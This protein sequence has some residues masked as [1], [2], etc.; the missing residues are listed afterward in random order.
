MAG[1]TKARFMVF[2]EG[3]TS[4]SDYLL[5]FKKGV[6]ISLLPIQPV[7]AKCQSHILSVLPNTAVFLSNCSHPFKTLKVKVYPVFTPN[8]YFWKNH[9]EPNKDK[10]EK[11]DTYIR[12]MR[13]IMIKHGGFKDGSQW[14]MEDRFRYLE[15]L[16]G[17][18]STKEE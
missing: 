4:N 3:C 13:S 2:P 18:T 17:V 5:S 8:E 7:T 9:W 14:S 11:V 10:E 1:K 16:N 15:A 6:F 12:V